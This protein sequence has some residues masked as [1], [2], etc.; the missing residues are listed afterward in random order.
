MFA[1]IRKWLSEVPGQPDNQ[2]WSSQSVPRT[3][4]RTRHA[5]N[6]HGS[7]DLDAGLAVVAKVRR[8]LQPDA[9]WTRELERGFEYW[10]GRLPMRVE[11]EPARSAQGLETFRVRVTTDLLVYTERM[12][13]VEEAIRTML[14]K[15]PLLSGLRCRTAD[16]QTTLSLGACVAVHTQTVEVLGQLLTDAAVLQLKTAYDLT[17]PPLDL[18]SPDSVFSE[19][20]SKVSTFNG[21]WPE[22]VDEMRWAADQVMAQLG[23]RAR[24]GTQ[25]RLKSIQQHLRQLFPEIHTDLDEDRLKNLLVVHNVPVLLLIDCIKHSEFGTGFLFLL[26]GRAKVRAS[27][28]FELIT[29]SNTEESSALLPVHGLGTWCVRDDGQVAFMAFVPM[30]AM[31]DNDAACQVASTMIFRG[32]WAVERGVFRAE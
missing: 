11:S 30:G 5:T 13:D 15:E 14:S 2:P 27:H 12:I 23:Q 18:A 19:P 16:G 10:P 29:R 6:V 22:K 17:K 7:A 31:M 26:A 8:T 24:G 25:Y 9:R 20:Y 28:A 32:L 21:E 3:G 4:E 1:S